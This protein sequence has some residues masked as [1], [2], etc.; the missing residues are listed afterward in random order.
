M[1]DTLQL[2]LIQLGFSAREAS[3]Y[4]TVAKLGRAQA[5]VIAKKIRAPR[6]SVYPSLESLTKRGLISA[7]IEGT[8]TYFS[9]N[10]PE[11]I[12]SEIH[13]ERRVIE[14]KEERARETLKKLRPMLRNQ[15]HSVPHLQ[16]FDG[17][18][19][20]ENMLHRFLDEWMESMQHTDDTLW[21]YQDHTFVQHYAGWLSLY[22][23]AKSSDHLIKLFSNESKEE[24]TLKNRIKGREVR[25]LPGGFDL[26]TTLWISGDYVTVIN[27]RVQPHYAFQVLDLVLA[28]NLR[29]IFQ[30]LWST[31]L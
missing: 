1:D 15:P 7:H 14:K 29:R 31:T 25:V 22:W 21:G 13:R 28:E 26:Q 10:E 24:T 19:N 20:V 18:E 12:L 8:T 9:A 2:E 5:T 17:T 6:T 4:L 3:V 27:T 11:A 30:S 23:K 16:Y